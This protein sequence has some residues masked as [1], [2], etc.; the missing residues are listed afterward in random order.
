MLGPGNPYQ[1]TQVTTSS[2]EKILLMLYDGALNFTKI[3]RDK[4]VKGDKP[5]KGKY[6]SL[7]QAIV[8]EL[9]N[10][11]NH[12]IAPVIARDLER[13]YVY[14]I[15]EYV[16]A[17]ISNNP[18]HLDNVIRIMSKMRDTWVEAIDLAKKERLAGGSLQMSQSR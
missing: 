1:K 4:M 15:D 12:D 17:N 8:A 13:L 16:A 14:M 11:L 2:P 6:I 7:A 10:T 18:T 3:A 9:M 5:G